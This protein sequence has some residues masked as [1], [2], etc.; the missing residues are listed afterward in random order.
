M[1]K[2][3]YVANSLEEAKRIREMLEMEGF[4][5]EDDTKK[6]KDPN[7]IKNVEIRVPESEAYDAYEVISTRKF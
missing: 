4:L 1:W 2:V 3:V 7:I 6:N 5:V